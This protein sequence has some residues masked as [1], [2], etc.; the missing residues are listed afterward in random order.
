MVIFGDLNAD[1][2]AL[3]GRNLTQL[4]S[5]QNLHYLITEPTRITNRSSTVLDQILTNAPNFVTKIEVTP[6]ISTND[7]CTI[8]AHFNFKIEKE[9]AYERHIWLFKEANFDQ[10]R[11]ALKNNDFDVC[12]ENENVDDACD[13]WTETFLNI[14]R[15]IIPNKVVTTRPNDSPR[16]TNELRLLKRRVLR[17]FHKHKRSNMENDWDEYKKLRNNYQKKPG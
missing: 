8:S 3:N 16:Y 9:K 1:F 15:T 13:T 7:H 5:T 11:E 17:A 14:A 10:F 2:N 4:C 6:P 12:F